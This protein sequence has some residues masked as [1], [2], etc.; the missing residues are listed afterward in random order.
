MISVIS[1]SDQDMKDAIVELEAA[2]TMFDNA[3][4]P[5]R[6]DEAIMRINAAHAR[7]HAIKEAAQVY[8]IAIQ[9]RE[10]Q[11]VK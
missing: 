5:F 2:Q 10:I 7:I 6:I 4:E 8:K 1:L 11:S 3:V 9:S